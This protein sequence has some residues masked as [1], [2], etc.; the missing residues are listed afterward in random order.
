[1][2]FSLA[3]AY[4][5]ETSALRNGGGTCH[6]NLGGLGGS[7]SSEEGGQFPE[8]CKLAFSSFLLLELESR[9]LDFV[10]IHAFGPLFPVS[11]F[12]LILFNKVLK[13]NALGLCVLYTVALRCVQNY[14]QHYN[15][16]VNEP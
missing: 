12:F 5:L 15:V 16:H 9:L 8:T 4:K 14:M 11:T 1:M 3:T 7:H 2:F 6:V 10:H 13:D